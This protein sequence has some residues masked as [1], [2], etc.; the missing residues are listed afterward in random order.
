MEVGRGGQGKEAPEGHRR[1][2]A[3]YLSR[4][5]LYHME[6]GQGGTDGDEERQS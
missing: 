2:M 5:P 4:Q 1:L 3:S 6:R